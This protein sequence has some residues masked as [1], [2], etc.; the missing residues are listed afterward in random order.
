MRVLN[1]NDSLLT[2]YVGPGDGHTDDE[3][4]RP[5]LTRACVVCVAVRCVVCVAV[6]CV[7]CVLCVVDASGVGGR[8]CSNITFECCSAI[9][10]L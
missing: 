6:R 10:N 7:V 3:L 5:A 4:Q 8:V 2:L 9:L 1:N